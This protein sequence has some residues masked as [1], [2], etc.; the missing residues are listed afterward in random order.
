MTVRNSAW[1]QHYII[2]VSIDQGK[3]AAKRWTQATPHHQKLIGNGVLMDNVRVTNLCIRIIETGQSSPCPRPKN[4]PH[5]KADTG[6]GGTFESIK[7]SPF[8]LNFI[9]GKILALT[10]DWCSRKLISTSLGGV[11][12]IVLAQAFSMQSKFI[13]PN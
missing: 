4:Q 7:Q 1:R 2:F 11:T 12:E 13:T 3:S 9:E 10:S 5:R 8:Q 6:K